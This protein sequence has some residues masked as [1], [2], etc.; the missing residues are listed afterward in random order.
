MES[1]EDYSDLNRLIIDASLDKIAKKKKKKKKALIFDASLNTNT[2]CMG[3][4]A[5]LH[6]I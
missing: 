6:M 3:A 1:W 5:K 4:S 2:V